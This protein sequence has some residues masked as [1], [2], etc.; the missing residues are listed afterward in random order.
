MVKKKVKRYLGL[1]I[2]S[3]FVFELLPF[4]SKNMPLAAENI[5]KNLI[6]GIKEEDDSLKLNKKKIS[7]NVDVESDER[8]S[9]IVQFVSEPKVKGISTLMTT[10]TEDKVDRDHMAFKSFLANVPVSAD[11]D[12]NIEINYE[13]TKVYNGISLTMKASDIPKLIECDV[14][15]KIYK[16]EIVTTELVEE[17]S[18]DDEVDTAMMDSNPFLNIDDLHHE[19]ITGEGIKV[20][21]LDTGIDYNHPDLQNVYK[22]FK[23]TDGDSTLQDINTV[24]GWDFVDNDADPMETTYEDWLASGE[25]EFDYYG[26]AYYT[27]HG[28]HVSGTIASTGS[29]SLSE[30]AVTGV[31][32]N[33]DLYGYRVLGPR[34]SGSTS[35]IIAAVEKSVTDGMDV[36]NMSLGN[37]SVNDSNDPMVDAV[38]NATLAGVVTVV[39]AGNAGSS[40]FTISSPA[41]AALPIVV[42]ASTVEYS[43]DTYEIKVCESEESITGK[44]M[45]KDFSSNVE[46][47]LD[48]ELELV[49]CGEGTEEEFSSV[50]VQGKIAVIDRG[51]ITFVEKANNAKEHGAVLC[52]LINNDDSNVMPYVGEGTGINTIALS[53]VDGDKLKESVEGKKVTITKNGQLI[54]NGDNLTEFSSV[55]PVVSSYDIRP[56]VVAP[57]YQVF[58]TL[59]EYI[60]NPSVDIN[61]YSV[62]YGRMSGTSM[63]TPHVAGIAALIL[64]T[65]PDFSPEDVK[66]ALM[67]TSDRIY[68]EEGESYSVNEIGAGRVNPYEAVHETVDIKASYI[69]KNGINN[70]EL[71]NVTGMLSFGKVIADEGETVNE[72]IPVTI[73]NDG[74]TNRSYAITVEYLSNNRCD[75]SE[76]AGVKINVPSEVNV[77][78]GSIS[79]FNVELN[80]PAGAY[81]NYEGYINITDK[82]TGDIYNM[83]FAVACKKSGFENLTY[84]DL[85]DGYGKGISAFTSSMLFNR[86]ATTAY[87]YSDIEVMFT[88]NEE[89]DYIDAFVKDIET[90]EYIGYAGGEEGYWIP[91]GQPALISSLVPNGRVK[92]IKDG[93][94]TEN[95]K[96]LDSGIYEIELIAYTTDGASFKGTLPM[97][98]INDSRYDSLTTENIKA[99]VTEISE[100]MFETKTW[101]DGIDYEGIWINGNINNSIVEEM[102]SKYGMDYLN[103]GEVNM[104]MASYNGEDEYVQLFST[105][106]EKNGDFTLAGIERSD[107]EKGYFKF[108][109]NESNAARLM[110]IPQAYILVD[111]SRQY[112][113]ID[114]KT[115]KITKNNK[116]EFM[117]TLNNASDI[118]E[119]SFTLKDTADIIPEIK[120]TAT[121]ELEKFMNENGNKIEFD[122][123]VTRDDN[124]TVCTV[125]FKVEAD[126]NE[127]KALNGDI[128]LFN[129]DYSIDSYEGMDEE[130]ISNKQ[131]LYMTLE[132][133]SS[134][135]TDINGEK[136]DVIAETME[137]SLEVEYDRT[138]IYGYGSTYYRSMTEG[139]I[140]A[141]DEEGNKYEPTYE[142]TSDWTSGQYFTFNNLP[143]IDGYYTL[144]FE[145][146][147][148]FDKKV[149]VKG[150]QLN[151]EG[152]LVGNTV[153]LESNNFFVGG[154]MFSVTGDVNNDGA[155]DIYDLNEVVKLYGQSADTNTNGD[156]VVDLSQDGIIDSMDVELILYNYLKK[157]YDR[158]DSKEPEEFM[159]G[160]DYIDLLMSIGYYDEYTFGE[161]VQA[162]ID[163]EE[164]F[165]GD[166]INVK[167]DIY[168]DGEYK[169]GEYGEYQY[170]FLVRNILD[171]SWEILY[172]GYSSNASLITE[173]PGNYEVKVRVLNQYGA[174][175]QDTKSYIVK[176]KE[177][178]NPGEPDNPEDPENPQEP[179]TPEDPSTPQEP[180]EP[181][182]PE[183]PNIPSGSDNGNNNLGS[184]STGNNNIVTTKPNNNRIPMT[185]GA[186]AILTL[187]VAGICIVS[188]NRFRKDK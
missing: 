68:T 104:V 80:I 101:Y 176:E 134:N 97:A 58:S 95:E 75:S 86:D 128:N 16:D 180:D 30:Y 109:L 162:Y 33:V 62:A 84:P 114:S 14:V 113:S 7:N 127:V 37:S 35:G 52:I 64:Q 45:I 188:G 25:E 144:V 130:L 123:E 6:E 11:G 8:V 34:G 125:N 50:D 183:N 142:K 117:I 105:I 107:F 120:V 51:N 53:K 181:S 171:N 172:Q 133:I 161:S 77:N 175:L 78:S 126:S 148:S 141:I 19:G 9:I 54:V 186:N 132:G 71:N 47:V 187:L 1:A 31:A 29:S 178:E 177:Q 67:N 152:E 48:K 135:F 24:K 49:Y 169:E 21:V 146:P 96:L 28:T 93:N 164:A 137:K 88:V 184:N 91:E 27:S 10:F 17:T 22:G 36:I 118:V 74:M 82:E 55:G 173:E 65:N 160:K 182:V 168:A 63:A 89:I 147:G 2:A 150:G 38:N 124:N 83:P 42:G 166:T 174:I 122:Y 40:S 81:G 155:I 20:G 5:A 110:N 87:Y 72:A 129:I 60:N 56:D 106:T 138:L 66:A 149:K 116:A 163:M 79:E 13:Y 94:I 61:D 23:S 90:G 143:V 70:E 158:E 185:G 32:P 131:F 156:L 153:T 121:K 108:N 44:I 111:P 139:N 85:G 39:A 154:G 26:N 3:L 12:S 157:D 112:L 76:A 167:A 165:V 103:Q 140:Y 151:T 59:P 102:K 43:L 57:G 159:D 4:N 73:T 15:K 179:N 119:G 170:Q 46:D 145:V 136:V 100:E 99:G 92:L 69:V 41:T 115:E 98:I 18:Y